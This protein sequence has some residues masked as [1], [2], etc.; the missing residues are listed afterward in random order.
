MTAFRLI[1]AAAVCLVLCA[2]DAPSLGAPSPTR[3]VTDNEI[4]IGSHSELGGQLSPIGIHTINGAL[5]RFEEANAAGGVHGRKIRYEVRD[6]AYRVP[7]ALSA[8]NELV[9]QVG[10]F[11][12]LLGLGTAHNNVVIPLL[13]Q[14]GVPNLFPVSGARSM[15]R[16]FRRVQFVARGIYYDEIQAGVR[17]YVQAHDIERPC[18]MYQDSEFGREIL[19]GAER[20]LAQFGMSASAITAHDPRETRFDRDV[21]TMMEAG[22][23]LVLLGTLDRD[24]VMIL[25]TARRLGFDSAQWVGTNAAYSQDAAAVPDRS[26]EGLAVF[27]HLAAIYPDDPDLPP[28]HAAWWHRYAERFGEPPDAYSMEGYRSADTL[29]RALEATGHALDADKLILAVE[30]LGE[31]TDPFGYRLEFGPRNHSGVH[32]SELSVVVNGR[33]QA[34]G[35]AVLY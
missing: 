13:E 20:Q 11:A 30:G 17:H 12:M 32:R 5:M 15:I 9:N 6:S 28:E 4:V 26:T 27:S 1:Q 7:Q 23:D 14:Q 3:G 25:S 33:W 24:A 8:A 2:C 18:I 31:F 35:E 21:R 29:L 10:I 34:A 22:C 19:E 16:P